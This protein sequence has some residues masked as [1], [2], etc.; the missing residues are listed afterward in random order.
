ME[1]RQIF[2]FGPS[3]QYVSTK[4]VEL[5]IMVKG[6]DGKDYV[7]RVNTYLV[8]ADVPFLCGKRTLENCDTHS[9]DHTK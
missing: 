9:G 1:C 5:P 8:E 6:M 2:K 4:M 3:K 7:L